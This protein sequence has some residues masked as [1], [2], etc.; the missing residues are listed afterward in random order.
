MLHPLGLDEVAQSVY[1]FVLAH[2]GCTEKEMSTLLCIQPEHAEEY[3]GLLSDLRLISRAEGRLLP[4]CPSTVFRPLLQRHEADLHRHQAEYAATRATAE[5]LIAE[6]DEI[7]GASVTNEWERLDGIATITARIGVL[8]RRSRIECLSLIPAGTQFVS[9]PKHRAVIAEE[10]LQNDVSV[11]SVYQDST[12][13]DRQTLRY[14]EW[15]T[16]EGGQIRTAPTLPTWMI[17][18]DRATALL[19]TSDD[20]QQCC[21]FQVCGAG[22]VTALVA[23]FDSVWTSATPLKTGQESSA[24]EPT[25]M[26]RELLR[27]LSQGLTDEAVCKKLSLGLRTVRRMVADLMARLDARSRFEAGANAVACGWIRLDS[28]LQPGRR[29]EG[30]CAPTAAGLV[31]LPRRS[32]DNQNEAV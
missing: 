1:R 17:I 11:W 15:L 23:L 21:A 31:P 26:E 2:Q 7:C 8:A 18:F 27:L 3:V 9:D 14:A 4:D 22:L 10:L 13:N 12:V 19:P 20:S 30:C 6:Y 16:K 29:R 25:A 5:R 32:M 24:D 28:A